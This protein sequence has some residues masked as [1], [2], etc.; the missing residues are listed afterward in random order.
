LGVFRCPFSAENVA[1]SSDGYELGTS[2]CV[3]FVIGK[4]QGDIIML[5]FRKLITILLTLAI[6]IQTP[7][8]CTHGLTANHR[9]G[10]HISRRND[11]LVMTRVKHCWRCH[12]K[13]RKGRQFFNLVVAKIERRFD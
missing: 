6:L 1:P 12:R 10:M 7:K 3:S 8:G 5:L 2:P 13:Y 11:G 9:S 4:T